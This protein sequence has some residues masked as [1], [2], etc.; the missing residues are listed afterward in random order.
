MDCPFC[1]IDT[2]K[3]CIL[4]EREHTRVIF[5]NPRLMPGHLLV[6]PKRHVEKL[7]ELNKEEKKEIFDV[8]IEF[9]ERILNSIARDA[10]L[11]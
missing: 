11:E 5:S 7:A 6:I 3:T 4:E 1:N 10:I 9:E 2:E 8:T